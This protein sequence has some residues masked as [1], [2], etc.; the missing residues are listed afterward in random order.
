MAHVR[1]QI[2]DAI[3]EILTDQLP[4]GEYVVF[5]SRKY[6]RNHDSGKA[7]VDIRFLNVNVTQETMG[8]DRTHA[9][10]LYV[11]VQRSDAEE[12]LDDALDQDEVLIT[13]VIEQYD[14]SDLLEAD[15]ELV[16]VNFTQDADSGSAL[17]A[18]ILRY[19][20]EYRIDKTNPEIVRE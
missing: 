18:I 16:Q 3:K 2:R 12:T 15:P 5:A 13:A 19:D 6:A 9:A 4:A 14:W 17:G 7:L 10:S 11:R 1:T 8:D 20:V